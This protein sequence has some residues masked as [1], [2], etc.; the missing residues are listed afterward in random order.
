VL[1]RYLAL[2]GISVAIPAS[3][4]WTNRYPKVEGF[5]HH[6]YLEGYELPVLNA[7]PSDP[8]P[9]PDG[10]AIALS[11]RGWLW[12]YDPDSGRAERLTRSA[13]SDFRPRWSPDGRQIVFVRDDSS[14][15]ALV[16]IDVASGAERVLV[17]EA[18]LEL[19]PVYSLDGKSLLYSSAEAGDL[20]LWRL[21]LESG[22]RARLTRT[23]G[24][25]LSPI[26]LPGG[27]V[28]FVTKE[29][30]GDTISVLD[31]GSEEPRVL[32]K[33]PIASQMRPALHP[34]GKSLVVPLPGPDSWALWLMDLE[35]GPSI[36]VTAG[37][38][39]PILPTISSDGSTVY[40]VEADSDQRFHLMKVPLGGGEAVDV[41]PTV[42]DYRETTAKVE[43]RTH[44]RGSRSPLPARLAITDGNGHPILPDRGQPRFDSQSG[45]VYTYSS[46]V[47]TVEAPSGEIRVEAAHGLAAPAASASATVGA[48]GSSSVE[49]D[50]TPLW[51]SA[52]TG[53]YS[54][55][56]HFHL[57]YG[58][59][60]RLRPEV[61]VTIL[62]AEDLDVGTPLMANLH[63][64]FNDLEWMTWSRL[65]SGPPLLAFGQEVRPHFLGHMG[66]IGISSPHWPWY[67]GPGYPVYGQDDRPNGSALEH[68]R[69]QG[70]I[71]AY[72][73]PVMAPGPFSEKGGANALPLTLVSEAM[74]GHLDTL[75]IACLWSDE[76]GTADVWYRLLSVGI[77]IAPSAGTDAFPNFY[78]SMAVGATRVYVRVP[79]TLNLSSY[80]EGLREGRSFVTN[81]PFL[82]FEA[83]GAGPGGVIERGS[84]TEIPWK[85]ELKSAVPV[86]RVEVLVNGEVAWTGKGLLSAGE[87]TYSGRI[88]APSGGWLAARALGGSTVWPAM[89]SYPFA[90]TGAV[91]LNEV[92][93]I[94]AKAARKAAREL[95]A[96]MDLAS[97]R[98][99]EGYRG[100]PIPKLKEGFAEA[101]RKL[102]A[103]GR[104]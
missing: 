13:G 48:G 71:N 14:D 35:G 89:D 80:L 5:S 85:L 73:H 53:W 93:S 9:S 38:G 75:E 100:A 49:L 1:A 50:L 44:R 33:E 2:A 61:L 95:L 47:L 25:E 83:G 96:W 97:K 102:E 101:R 104:R 88:T 31:S 66:L 57:N 45:K 27:G 91:W 26:P 76:M 58:G 87:E 24:L 21:D 56:H 74:A 37:D 32:V 69:R 77:P 54:G 63:T 6:V 20:D 29:N 18:P 41:T 46:G 59:T 10:R 103:L 55:D 70:G 82:D 19:D 4:Q 81:G 22:Q 79:G 68:S 84:A 86:E 17:D 15:T 51:S 7:G 43:I 11:A 12:L 16:Q 62:E 40:F 23:K 90:H 8:A 60:Y 52:D 65:A 39:L 34:G 78:R 64:R 67:W 36:R 99:D 72:V 3:A 94:D 30:R 98:L 28:V 42:W 92:G